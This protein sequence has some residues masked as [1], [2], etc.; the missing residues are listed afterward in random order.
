[1]RVRQDRAVAERARAELHAARA[2]RDDTVGYEQLGD[3]LLYCGVLAPL[4][5]AGEVATLDPRIDLRIAHV[6]SE[7]RGAEGLRG[8]LHTS[9]GAQVEIAEVRRADRVG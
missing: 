2:A 5:A 7:V 1:R 6:R 3:L 4:V 9:G 8:R